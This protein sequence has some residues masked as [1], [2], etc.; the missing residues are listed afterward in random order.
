[1]TIEDKFYDDDGCEYTAELIPARVVIRKQSADATEP[2]VVGTVFPKDKD[3][4]TSLSS[5]HAL[6]HGV[7]PWAKNKA[8]ELLGLDVV[9]PAQVRAK[10]MKATS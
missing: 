5:E 2:S 8:R 1:M 6:I 10:A 7:G 3:V 9:V 4:E